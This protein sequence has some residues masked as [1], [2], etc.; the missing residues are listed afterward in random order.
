MVES[1]TVDSTEPERTQ[2]AGPVGETKVARKAA[3]SEPV[4]KGG[5][6]AR[7]VAPEQPYVPIK[8]TKPGNVRETERPKSS[9]AA[10]AAASLL[11]IK[12]SPRAKSP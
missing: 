11:G 1:K 6:K 10:L 3:V 9:L 8:V 12:V 7:E 2:S 5:G 4:H